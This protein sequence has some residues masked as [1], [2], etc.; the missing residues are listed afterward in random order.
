MQIPLFEPKSTWRPPAI[1]P[2]LSGTISLDLETYDPDIKRAG[3]GYK[4]GNGKV[5]GVA[6]ADKH[7]TV[8]LPFDHFGGDNLCKDIVLQYV[9]NVITSCD[10]II[11]ANATYDLGWLARTGVTTSKPIRDIQ[12]AEALIDEEKYSYSLDSIAKKYLK[13]GKK[14]DGLQQAADSYGV[15]AKGDM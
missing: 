13:K 3:P 1:L 2:E 10:E 9:C 5:V 6:L 14:E 4:T 11:M 8:Y 15:D 7:Q 12:V